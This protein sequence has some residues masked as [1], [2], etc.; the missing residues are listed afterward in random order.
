MAQTSYS[1]RVAL[2]GDGGTVFVKYAVFERD[3]FPVHVDSCMVEISPEV[4][5]RGVRTGRFVYTVTCFRSTREPRRRGRVTSLV[6]IPVAEFGSCD[7]QLWVRKYRL[8]EGLAQL[9]GEVCRDVV[10]MYPPAVALE[11]LLGEV[12]GA[13]K[14]RPTPTSPEAQRAV[15]RLAG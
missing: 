6:H 4:D 12:G 5:E 1:R 8:P 2:S 15:E 14:P 10:R 11:R 7:E 9:L 3:G 13:G